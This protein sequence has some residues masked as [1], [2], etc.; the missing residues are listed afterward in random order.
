MNRIETGLGMSLID[1]NMC[2]QIHCGLLH[3][4]DIGYRLTTQEKQEF[5]EYL[6]A[7]AAQTESKDDDTDDDDDESENGNSNDLTS[8]I[9]EQAKAKVILGPDSR[10]VSIPTTVTIPITITI[11]L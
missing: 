10:P 6:L 5:E 9:S 2:D 1:I 4:Y 11:N 8:D 7:L 3:S